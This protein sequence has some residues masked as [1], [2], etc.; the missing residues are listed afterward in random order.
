MSQLG[1]TRKYSLRADVFRFTPESGPT[2]S[3]GNVVELGRNNA[4]TRFPSNMNAGLRFK[5]FPGASGLALRL[6][7][8]PKCWL[9]DRE[10]GFRD[11]DPVKVRAKVAAMPRVESGPSTIYWGLLRWPYKSR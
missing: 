6:S 5:L 11:P 7:A 4:T 9:N 1:Q 3:S 10:P 8:T 2:P